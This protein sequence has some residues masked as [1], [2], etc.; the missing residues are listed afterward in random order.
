MRTD[1]KTLF[2]TGDT[3]Q[4][5]I[6]YRLRLLRAATGKTQTEVAEFAGMKLSAYQHHERGQSTIRPI[7]AE[8]IMGALGADHNWIYSGRWSWLPSGLL[9]ALISASST[10]ASG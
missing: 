2:R 3:S 7:Q 9:Q 10:D 1:L 6:G 4:D 5:A 8:G